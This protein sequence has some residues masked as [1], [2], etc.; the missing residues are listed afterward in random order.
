[1]AGHSE[2]T[3]DVLFHGVNVGNSL[4]VQSGGVLEKTGAGTTM[5]VSNS[6][7]S[8]GIAVNNDGT[9]ASPVGR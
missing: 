7:L 9:L 4:N 5:S 1:M 3:T 6:H 2:A 8:H